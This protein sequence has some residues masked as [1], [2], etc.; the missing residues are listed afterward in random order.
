MK[1]E[2]EHIIV[3]NK[4]HSVYE[5]TDLS[6]EL[7]PETLADE[8]IQGVYFRDQQDLYEFLETYSS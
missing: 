8:L 7:L 3:Y 1:S 2:G 6:P 5:Y 4:D